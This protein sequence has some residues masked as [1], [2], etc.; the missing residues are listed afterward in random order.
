MTWGWRKI[1][2]IRNAVRPSFWSIIRSG[3]Q[4]NVWSDNWCHL[5]PLRSFITP[6][7]IA[8]AGFNLQATVAEVIDE[9]GQWKWPQAWYDVYPVLIGLTVNQQDPQL[10]DRMVWKDVEGHDQH[11][12]SLEVWH[13]LRTRDTPVKWASM[14]WFSQCIPR[15]SFHLWLVIKNKLKTQDRLA[16]WE[17]GSETN[18]RLMCCPLCKHGTDSRDHLFFVCGFASQVWSNIRMLVDLENVNDSWT[19]IAVWME[20]YSDSKRF[21]HIVCKLAISASSYYIWQERNNRLFTSKE[22]TAEQ[23]TEK[24]KNI[25]RLRLMGFVYKGDLDYQRTLTKWQNLCRASDED[26]G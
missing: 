18:R 6:R 5:S 14:V 19:S 12:S 10:A 22:C 16:V 25:V 13:T 2:S 26:P 15:H 17:V 11:F 21:K 9:N 20:R 1:L 24:I 4:T 7:H 8:N 3:K 23:V